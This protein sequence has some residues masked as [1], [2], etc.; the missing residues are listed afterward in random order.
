MTSNFTAGTRD[1]S[2]GRAGEPIALDC[3]GKGG[4]TFLGGRRL[5][6]CRNR[7]IVRAG[8][9]L[10]ELLIVL[11]VLAAVAGLGSVALRKPL[12]KSRMRSATQELQNQLAQARLRAMRSGTP[13]E[14]RY[15]VGGT[16]YRLGALHNPFDHAGDVPSAS[17]ASQGQ[18]SFTEPFD[19]SAET[20]LVDAAR[21]SNQLEH[22]GMPGT[23][24][25]IDQQ[26]PSG[27]R[28]VDP[29]AEV[30]TLGELPAR[31]SIVA[32]AD[33]LG[34]DERWSAPLVFRPDGRVRSAVIR[35][36]SESGY[37]ADVQVRGLTGAVT[38]TAPKRSLTADIEE[39]DS[40]EAAS[41]DADRMQAARSFESP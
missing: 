15:E 4:P 19:T 22:D 3:R 33:K 2:V 23:S 34:S 40:V 39:T 21:G 8:F 9:S 17:L 11:A 37:S 27:I 12:A 13:I 30:T 31:Q 6:P 16:R 10:L 35:L 14:L 24:Q 5:T 29:G 25:Q 32:A 7:S 36:Q 26:L 20:A 1:V 38:Y 41:A 18:P 28:F